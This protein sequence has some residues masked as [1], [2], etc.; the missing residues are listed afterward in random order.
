MGS[1]K[2]TPST[3]A[4]TRM[5]QTQMMLPVTSARMMH[6]PMAA[7]TSPLISCWPG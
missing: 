7:P 5:S 1:T 4:N 3:S 2:M 6:T